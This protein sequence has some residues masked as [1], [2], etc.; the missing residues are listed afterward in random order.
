VD[1]SRQTGRPPLP[2][3]R[4]RTADGWQS[5]S[6]APAT[7]TRFRYGLGTRTASAAVALEGS[8]S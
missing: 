6:S 1:R 2:T 8:F 3:P 7:R 5:P 4:F